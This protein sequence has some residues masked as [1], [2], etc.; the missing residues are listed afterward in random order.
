MRI[1]NIVI[2]ASFAL[3]LSLINN[4]SISEKQANFR[5]LHLKYTKLTHF[6]EDKITNELDNCTKEDIRNIIN[7]YDVLTDNLDYPY[8]GFIRKRVKTRF[9]GKRTLPN[10]LNCEI[11][12]INKDDIPILKYLNST[13]DSKVSIVIERNDN[14]NIIDNVNDNDNDIDNNDITNRTLFGTNRMQR[15]DSVKSFNDKKISLLI[16]NNDNDIKKNYNIIDQI[17]REDSPDQQITP[18]SKSNKSSSSPMFN[19]I[20]NKDFGHIKY[21]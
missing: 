19:H 7:D 2:N 15:E 9:F 21:I 8:P 10:I 11:V 17:K 18:L 14:D 1:P 20:N 6:I 16:E 3:I 13:N 4:F 12:F 5:S